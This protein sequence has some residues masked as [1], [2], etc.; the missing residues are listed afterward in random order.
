MGH[1]E[2]GV[3]LDTNR[4]SDMFNGDALL[5]SFLGTCSDVRVPLMVLAEL[6]AGFYGGNR[7]AQN[8]E[9]VRLFLAKSTVS[10]IYPGRET[11][12]QYARLYLQLKRIGQPIPV[13]DMWIAAMAIEH[14]LTLITRDK[15]FD[16]IPQLRLG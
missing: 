13:N 5:G 7:Q 11:A 16:C 9:F 10:V 15:H 8:E 3:A 2:V 6:K 1:V 4:L 12:D 14:D